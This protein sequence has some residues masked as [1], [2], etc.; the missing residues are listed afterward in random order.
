[1]TG[2]LALSAFGTDS[3]QKGSGGTA[4]LFG[5]CALGLLVSMLSMDSW[6]E[7]TGASDLA[8]ASGVGCGEPPV[9]PSRLYSPGDFFDVGLSGVGSCE[10]PDGAAAVEDVARGKLTTMALIRSFNLALAARYSCL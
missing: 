1:M 4:S 3:R 10:S 6:G 8:L 2:R 5:N 7:D 9:M